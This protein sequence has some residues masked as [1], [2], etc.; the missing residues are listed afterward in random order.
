[1]WSS[2]TAA[3]SSNLDSFIQC[4]TPHPPSRS[5]PQISQWHAASGYFNLGDVWNCYR[6]W[7]A[8]G[9]GTS[10]VLESGEDIMQYYVPYLSA[11]QIYTN[12]SVAASRNPREG[13]YVVE[14]ESDC[15]SDD[16]GLSNNSSR[17]WDAISEDSGSGS[18][19]DALSPTTNKL[20]YLY[21]HYFEMSSPY[22][23]VP[24]TQKITEL[25]PNHPGLITLTSVD[26]S[27]ASWMAVAWYPI[28]H[29]PSRKNYKDL[30]TCFLTYHT[31]SSSFQDSVDENNTGCLEVSGKPKGASSGRISLTPFGL[32]SYKMQGDVWVKPDTYDQ[33]RL[34][35][36]HR[37]ADSWLKQLNVHH[38]DFNFFT[39]HNIM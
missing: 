8:Y 13:S 39:C 22:W 23:R 20:G 12:K 28:Y 31:L 4:V 6:E 36:L 21:F 3:P 32:T 24:L 11:I 14:F 29:I 15:W 1:M 18:E 17:T 38:H 2:S 27:P 5:L 25:A 10:V 35:N 9:A 37:A 33:E 26:L 30:S 16:S 34:I 7:S 19:Q